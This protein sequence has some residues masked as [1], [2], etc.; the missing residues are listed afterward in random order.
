M[1]EKPKETCSHGDPGVTK[2]ADEQTTFEKGKY[3]KV[4]AVQKDKSFK[5]IP[6]VAICTALLISVALWGNQ[7]SAKGKP[8]LTDG[9]GIFL[10]IYLRLQLWDYPGPKIKYEI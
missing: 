2:C 6:N 9:S 3:S 5:A 8:G 4:G 7:A 10:F 1:D